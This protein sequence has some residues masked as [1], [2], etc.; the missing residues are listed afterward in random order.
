MQNFITALKAEH[1]KKK[2]TGIFLL[3]MI[4]GAI[5]PLIWALIAI[6]NDEPQKRDALPYDFFLNVIER[7]LDI[8]A[9]FFF[10]LLIIITVSRITQ[11]DHKNG[12]W[13]LMETQPIDKMSIYF[14][15]FTMI[16]AANMIAIL[17]L[18]AFSFIGGGLASLFIELPDA[19]QFTF[20]AGAI[21]SLILRLFLASILLSAFQHLI[22]VIIPSF[23]WSIVI[24]FFGLLSNLFLIA[25]KVVP[26]WYPFEIL[27]KISKFKKGSEM[28]YWITY[29]EV[30]SILCGILVLYIGYKWYKHKNFK[31]AFFSKPMRI[32]KLAAVLLIFGGLTA[33][34]LQPNKMLNYSETVISG[35][36]DG[37]MQYRNIFV[38]D[39]FVSDTIAVVPITNN[40]F[41]YT[42]EKDIVLNK[43][44]LSF[45]GAMS[46]AAIFGNK[47]SIYIDLKV[48]KNGNEMKVTGTRLAENQYSGSTE[49]LW[50]N[51]E[52]YLQENLM[53]ESPAMVTNAIV[54]EW[55]DFMSESDKF[56]TAD[57][58]VPRD[59]YMEKDKM[60]ITIKY[61][62]FWN[63]FV[64]KR[65]ALYPASPTPE[66]A[67]I[68]TMKKRVPLDD[69]ALLNNSGYF[70][71]VKST[72]IAKDK[73]EVD[74]NTKSLRAIAKLPAGSFKDKMLYS[75]LNKSLKEAS[76]AG[77]RTGLVA[78][79][80]RSFKDTK[81]NAIILGN[82]KVLESLSKSM[83]APAF[84]AVTIDNKPVSLAS[85]KGQYVIIDVW[86]TWCGP[87]KYQSPFF[88][89][90]ALK[91][92]NQPIQF[93]AAST[94]KKIADWYV[95][96][97]AKSKSVMQ[98]HI[99]DLD[100]FE[101]QYAVESIPRFILIDPQGNFVDSALPFPNEQVFEKLL[102]QTLGLAEEK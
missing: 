81:Y 1:I 21:G 29:S 94:D 56:R 19:A 17:S 9:G 52:Y 84:D 33:Y 4:L 67:D 47:D 44:R 7:L 5:S 43:Y 62:N 22:S 13:Q 72:L 11:L 63:T 93:V 55:K 91:Y 85:L 64:K 31:W 98:L 39:N 80:A 27:L 65:E 10:P 79:Y 95:E 70:D 42:I 34:T 49:E 41:N 88:E 53:L 100:R 86:A 75:Q 102:R 59:D 3:S 35:K 54:N 68:K 15:K 14:S 76:T 25:F 60:M 46:E 50:S 61:L 78:A 82:N 96:A 8:F 12:G 58:Y 26:A 99:N 48:G 38:I 101:K 32:V 24:G 6:F 71:Y 45:D 89:K 74:E 83:P 87:C 92:K 2:G 40:A 51:V 28:G 20:D 30:V 16:L 73:E 77:E 18:V 23:I 69:E 97:K 90:F 37:K 57:N 66:T 36:I